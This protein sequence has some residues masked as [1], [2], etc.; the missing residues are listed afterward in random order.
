MKEKLNT[1]A[2]ILIP[3][4][5][6]ASLITET[7]IESSKKSQNIIDNG[8]YKEIEDEINRRTAE[9]KILELEA[10]VSQEVAIAKRIE[11]AIDVEIEEYYEA[12]GSGKIGAN[13]SETGFG[14][15]LSGH[16]KKIVK[17][18]YKFK[19]KNNN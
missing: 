3:T 10:K 19:G 14:G 7:I 6:I 15:E 13:V 5:G 12:G 4:Y 11:D 9:T 17:R 2:K 8:S 1:T 18:I 16:G